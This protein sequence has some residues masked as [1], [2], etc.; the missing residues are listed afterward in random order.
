[1]CPASSVSG[2]KRSSSLQ[3]NLSSHTHSSSGS[4]QRFESSS[5]SLA[6]A[7]FGVTED[8]SELVMQ[9]ES[10]VHSLAGQ[11]LPLA[12]VPAIS[13]PDPSSSLLRSPTD[14]HSSDSP[15]GELLAPLRLDLMCEDGILGRGSTGDVRISSCGRVAWKILKPALGTSSALPTDPAPRALEHPHLVVRASRSSF[16]C[17]WLSPM[18][19]QWQRAPSSLA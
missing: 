12:P 16:V 10:W 19:A 17:H 14:S 9:A 13:L 18:R 15:T 5:E 8:V 2:M 1:M 3:S 7:D 6:L 11:R 4:T